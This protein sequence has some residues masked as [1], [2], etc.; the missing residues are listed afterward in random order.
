[1]GLGMKTTITVINGFHVFNVRIF[2]IRPLGFSFSFFF[3]L[4]PTFLQ[5]FF[6]FVGSTTI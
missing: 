1:M 3:S 5:L 2:T 6:F 4:P